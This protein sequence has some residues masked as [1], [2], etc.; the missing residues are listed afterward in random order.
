MLKARIFNIQ[1]MS[2]E[3][4]PGIRTSVFFKGCPLKCIWCQNPE[5]LTRDVHL[6]HEPARCIG[7]G[8]C[9]KAC[10]GGALTPAEEGL[11][12][13]ESCRLCLTC[14]EKC[15]ARAIRVIGEDIAVPELVSKLLQDRPF[16]KNSGGGVTFTGGE[17][18]MQHE[19]LDEIIPE[20]KKE[21]I[22]ICIDTSGYVN[23]KIFAKTVREADM[24]LYDLK[25]MDD[26]LHRLY[27]GVSNRPVLENAQH[28][29]SAGIPVWVR[30]AVIPGFTGDHSNISG[31]AG[32]IRDHMAP[33][34]ERIDLLGY[35]DLCVND[36]EK[37]RV[38]YRLKDTPR[39]KESEMQELR[40]LMK[41]SGIENITISNYLKGE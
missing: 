10:P 37:M 17:C 4:G 19:F 18:L 38:D 22:H 9:V 20:L 21:D 1:A 26:N 14:S 32:F 39:V 23:G 15:P 33:A 36:Y 31:I 34:V 8:T 29:G 30:I 25:I 16:Y 5:G 11:V 6:V 27:T 2:T 40:E 41:T 24:V 28:L 7:C 3:D 13:G 35:N 12:F